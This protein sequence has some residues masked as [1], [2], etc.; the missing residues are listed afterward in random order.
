MRT[1]RLAILSVFAITALGCGGGVSGGPPSV[2]AIVVSPDSLQLDVGATRQLV[3]T[4]VDAHGSQVTG[5]AIVFASADTA[6][7]TSTNAGAVTGRRGG[8]TTVRASSGSIT[9]DVPVAVRARPHL[10]TTQIGIAA[11]PFGAAVSSLGVAYVTQ[12][13]A[14]ALTR[15]SLATLAVTGTVPVGRDPG[16]V[17]FTSSGTTAY[18]TNFIA[19]TLGKVDVGTGIQTA[20]V[21]LGGDAYR[22]LVSRDDARVLVTSGNGTLQ[23]RQAGNLALLSTIVVGAT[24]NGIASLGDTILYVSS[25]STGTIREV[26]LR[27]GA[28]RR[29][30]PVGG[31]PQDIALSQDGR[32]LFM[33]DE[34]R[35]VVVV[36]LASGTVTATVPTTSRAFGLG[37]GPDGWLYVTLPDVGSV[38]I[39]DPLQPVIAGTVAVGGQPRR[40]AFD[41]HGTA[42]LI[43]NERGWVDV[44]R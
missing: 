41:S 20:T 40:V 28:V 25:A 43:P 1:D 31:V 14:D 27:T 24:P 18:V 34:T 29:T 11:R 32:Q 9:T 39:V 17:A 13:D 33:A 42:V 35:G 8:R 15:V 37:L 38:I 6:I 16:D 12:Q 44:L 2:A 5:V 23:I 36:S 3:A 22:V 4:A 21:P 26:D 19:G 10:T 30:L 7:A